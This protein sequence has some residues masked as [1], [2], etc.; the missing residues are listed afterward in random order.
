M[1]NNGESTLRVTAVGMTLSGKG[2]LIWNRW[3]SRRPRVFIVD[4]T[5]EWQR[6]KVDAVYSRGLPD[7][8]DKFEALAH[9]P[10]WRIVCNLS[11]Q[12]I[13][14]LALILVPEDDIWGQSPIVPLGGASLYLPE[15]DQS[16]DPNPYDK[17]RTLWRRG[18]HALLDVFA[19]TQAPS[20]TSKEIFKNSEI[21][22]VMNLHYSEDLEFVR[23]LASTPEQAELALA[24]I[25]KPHHAAVFMPQVG[26][27]A[28]LTPGPAALAP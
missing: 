24:W 4:H 14:D 26:R 22:P 10:R 8:L 17:S 3:I 28:L 21:V 7:T 9:R 16:I 27:L 25:K 6:R 15:V 1:S 5:G 12:D 19:D 2:T 23:K 11:R 20:S 13:A 18:R